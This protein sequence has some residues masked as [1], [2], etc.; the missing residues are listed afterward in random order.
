MNSER[1]FFQRYSGFKIKNRIR[2]IPDLPDYYAAC[3]PHC[4][5]N[6]THGLSDRC[7]SRLQGLI[8]APAVIRK[9]LPYNPLVNAESSRQSSNILVLFHDIRRFIKHRQHRLESSRFS[10]HRTNIMMG[11]Q[12]AK[13]FPII[14]FAPAWNQTARTTS[15]AT[16]SSSRPLRST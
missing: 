6:L 12:I 2:V 3:T 5:V 14:S 9:L 15:T 11:N 8:R 7:T 10:V 16:S 4:I 13:I 1:N